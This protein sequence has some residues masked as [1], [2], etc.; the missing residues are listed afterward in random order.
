VRV[1]ISPGRNY[2]AIPD[3]AL[4]ESCRAESFERFLK[5]LPDSVSERVCQDKQA[6][7]DM[8]IWLRLNWP[9][10][11]QRNVE[12]DTA[13]EARKSRALVILVTV[14]RMEREGTVTVS[15]W[16]ADIDSADEAEFMAG[17][18]ATALGKQQLQSANAAK[19]QPTNE[20]AEERQKQKTETEN[21]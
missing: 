2:F 16:P 9:R 5:N 1:L 14:A 19:Q 18:R 17:V 6:A 13:V 4:Y 8:M 20:P 15:K 7:F 12:I 11:L 10:P 21:I 3:A